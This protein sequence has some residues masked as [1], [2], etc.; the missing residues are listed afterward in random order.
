MIAAHAQANVYVDE[1]PVGIAS[2]QHELVMADLQNSS[3]LVRLTSTPVRADNLALRRAIVRSGALGTARQHKDLIGLRNSLMNCIRGQ[4]RY[5]LLREVLHGENDRLQCVFVPGP[6][7]AIHW[8]RSSQQSHQ[9]QLR[10]R[11]APAVRGRRSAPCSARKGSPGSRRSTTP[12]HDPSG[13]PTTAPAKWINVEGSK[14]APIITTAFAT[15]KSPTVQPTYAFLYGPK[16]AP[17]TTQLRSATV[18]R[19]MRG[20]GGGSASALA[21]LAP[22]AAG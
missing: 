1:T 9:A 21:A 22:P 11:R 8:T 15:A 18:E 7:A 16:S 14:A 19:A 12:V 4:L 5:D 17:M 6:R 13:S 3:P 2:A 20:G 10:G